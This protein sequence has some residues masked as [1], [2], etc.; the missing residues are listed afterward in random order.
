MGDSGVPQAAVPAGRDRPFGLRSRLSPRRL[1]PVAALGVCACLSTIGMGTPDAAGAVQRGAAAGPAA[2]AGSN[3]QT[4]SARGAATTGSAVAGSG[5]GAAGRPGAASGVSKV[6]TAR[7]AGA[8]AGLIT[9]PAAAPGTAGSGVPHASAG[10]GPG[11]TPGSPATGPSG[12]VDCAKAKCIALTFDDGP[13]PDTG[14]LLR[15]LAS[16]HARV[17]FFMLGSNVA[18]HPG[19]VRR[20]V[21]AG[22][23]I[24]N[25]SYGHPDLTRLPAEA[26]R[27]QLTRTATAVVTAAG[28]RPGLLRP[29]YGAT[30]AQVAAVARAQRL[31]L[32]LWSVDTLDWRD[33][34]PRIVEARAL[35]GAR[36]GA[37][38]LM[39][40]IHPTTISA[41]PRILDRL[42]A[43]GFVFVTV[44]EL[45][46]GTPSQ[47]GAIYR[48][49]SSS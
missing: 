33:R 30:D 8:P 45:L 12:P 26:V 36:R 35:A 40:D 6:M 41:V 34:D 14:R 31:P 3:A 17:T 29:P 44:S 38:V 4:R 23:E 5:E 19:M 7:R 16:R 32:V 25:H 27:A 37:I 49:R 21:T 9:T 1:W 28:V 24:G 48:E 15:I 11:S 42:A 22:H 46:K 13:V 10:G 18:G 39:H 43:R 47:P 20:A 2:T